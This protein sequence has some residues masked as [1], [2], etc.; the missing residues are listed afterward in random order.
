MRGC[1]CGCGFC[2]S[3]IFGMGICN[4][5][6]GGSGSGIFGF[7]ATFF[8]PVAFFGRFPPFFF[9]T[10]FFTFPVFFVVLL[11]FFVLTFVILGMGHKIVGSMVGAG[12]RGSFS[13][14]SGFGGC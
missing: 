4:G 14:S 7:R 2:P 10:F 5:A 1:I 9:F 11:R 12:N 3:W 13:S 6:T 8:L